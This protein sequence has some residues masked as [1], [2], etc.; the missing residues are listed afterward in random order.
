[1]TDPIAAVVRI[2]LKV[3]AGPAKTRALRSHEVVRV[4]SKLGLAGEVPPAD[5]RSVYARALADH[6]SPARC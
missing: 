4:L 5:F 3:A 1:V 2:L 6:S